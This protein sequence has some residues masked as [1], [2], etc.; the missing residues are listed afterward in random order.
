MK[1]CPYC[2]EE[3][4]DAA[5]KCR[6][7]HRFVAPVLGSQT[8][9]DE[10]GGSSTQPGNLVEV[11][12]SI[13]P[14]ETTPAK[15]VSDP[16]P[17]GALVPEEDSPSLSKATTPIGLAADQASARSAETAPGT[18][19]RVVASVES[20]TLPV[21]DPERPGEPGVPLK[22]G[23]A[24][25]SDT[26]PRSAPPPP[27]SRD[28][29][30][31]ARS[32]AQERVGPRRLRSRRLL[33]L[34]PVVCLVVAAVA[35]MV[36]VSSRKKPFVSAPTSPPP[37]PSATVASPNLTKNL[38]A[39]SGPSWSPDGTQIAFVSDRD[40]NSEIYL[41]QSD[42]TDVRRLTNDSAIDEEPTWSPDGTRIAFVSDRT[43]NLDIFTVNGD[44]GGLIRLT[45]DQASDS[46]PA[47]SPDGTRI[48]FV[49]DRDGNSEIYTLEVDGSLVTRLTTTPEVDGAPTWS[50]DGK[51]IAF[52]TG[53]DGN[54]EIYV[55]Q[56]D[57]TEPTNLTDNSATDQGPTWSPD[58]SRIAFESDRI[59]NTDIFVMSADGSD[60]ID[61]SNDLVGD[62]SQAAWS[63]DGNK[64]A[65]VSDRDGNNEVYA[66]STAQVITPLP[67]ETTPSPVRTTPSPLE[68]TTAPTFVTFGDGTWRI[69]A[70]IQAGT[71]RTREG[72][73]GC[74]WARLKGFGGALDDILAN[75][76]TD[77]STIVTIKA[78]DKGFETAGCGTWTSD[79]S[80]I[81]DSKTSFSDG[82]FIVGTDIAAGT[83]RADGGDGCYWARLSGFTGDM[84]DVIAN[85]IPT[86]SAIVTIK[87]SDKGF[88]T[89]GCGTWGK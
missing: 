85:D 66:V 21:R 36:S 81:T 44:G 70:D 62:D 8:S 51:T 83:Y 11:S 26:L 72:S 74:Y 29:A 28:P 1:K 53:R 89:S 43:G 49:S 4:Q 78:S 88:S 58:S 48:A 23:I 14:T 15:E 38:G 6:W 60:Q 12:P 24:P 64:L 57:G 19:A 50:P 2:A 42:G 9:V 13:Q 20:W 34:V 47:W 17:G 39:D 10:V 61:F 46:A 56:E 75:E 76:I 22:P 25:Q 69:P 32:Y 87:A 41:M 33:V 35:V 55:M 80:Q 45:R 63:P 7:C 86:G 67:L 27:Q 37:T 79:L 31:A 54:K 73:S 59:G 16:I 3:I 52:V 71:Y 82:T 40:G 77:A 18:E 84:D 5:L 30:Q 68:T 65:F